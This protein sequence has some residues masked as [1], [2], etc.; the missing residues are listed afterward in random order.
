P[1]EPAA[2]GGPETAPVGA[3]TF[4]AVSRF[5]PWQEGTGP[6]MEERVQHR[7]PAPVRLRFVLGSRATDPALPAHAPLVDVLPA[8]LPVL[9]LDACPRSS[10]VVARQ[11]GGRPTTTPSS[12]S[13]Y[14]CARWSRFAARPSVAQSNVD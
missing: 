2:W 7:T 14:S 8:V 1:E 4:R 3:A 6:L 10:S 11:C 13:P 5:R 12:G 9:D